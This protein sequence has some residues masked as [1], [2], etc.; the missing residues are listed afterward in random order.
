MAIVWSS[1]SF[2]SGCSLSESSTH[3]VALQIFTSSAYRRVG[4]LRRHIRSLIK[5]ENTSGLRTEPCGT[6][7]DEWC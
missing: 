5:I 3:F 7:G 6:P 1:E 2:R 4:Q